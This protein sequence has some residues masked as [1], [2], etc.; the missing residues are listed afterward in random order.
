[1]KFHTAFNIGDTGYVFSHDIGGIRK[2]TV[3]QIRV[4]YTGRTTKEQDTQGATILSYVGS[5][6]VPTNYG[7]QEESYKE[8]YMC[9]ETGIGSG[10]LHTLNEHIFKTEDEC[11][12]ANEALIAERQA[13]LESRQRYRAE[14]EKLRRDRVRRD[15][16]ALQAIEAEEMK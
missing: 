5:N 13:E 2:L 6:M 14:Q 1:M 15:F 12:I 3:G 10:S 9:Y 16:E 8:V 4:E 11:I 7:P